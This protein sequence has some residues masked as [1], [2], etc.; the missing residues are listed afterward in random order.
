M[1]ATTASMISFPIH[2]AASGNKAAIRR[3]QPAAVT[4]L[5]PESQSNFRTGGKFFR[6]DRRSRQG[7]PID[8][9]IDR[10]VKVSNNRGKSAQHSWVH[11][12]QEHLIAISV[13]NR[14]DVQVAD[15][16]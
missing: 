1:P 13:P 10:V 15:F 7:L 3:Q 4:S 6:A 5:G 9:H 8:F 14:R 16:D 11:G 2:N 12:L